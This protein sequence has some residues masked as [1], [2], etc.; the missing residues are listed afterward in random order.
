MQ[1]SGRMPSS[2]PRICGERS[3]QVKARFSDEA[4]SKQLRET[5]RLVAVVR[6]ATFRVREDF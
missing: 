2:L 1:H 3:V 5:Q 4:G 6:A